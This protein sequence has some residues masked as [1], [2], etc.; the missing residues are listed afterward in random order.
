MK[1]F[2]LSEWA[3]N[4]RAFTA[5]L[6][7]LLMLGRIF[8]Y[9]QFD[10]MALLG[11]IALAGIIIRNSVILVD[12]IEQDERSGQNAWSAIIEA[13]V[14]GF[15]PIIL[16]AAAAILA[17]ISLS[18]NDFVGPQAIA[19]MGGL[20]IATVLIFFLPPTVCSLVQSQVPGNRCRLRPG[21]A[22]RGRTIR[23]PSLLD[24]RT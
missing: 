15:R 22:T 17:M 13:S 11:I 24:G 9:S 4:H 16:T 10:F 12:Q 18:T 21:Q 7:A 14:R 6:M 2:N 20:L 8:A 5:F 3:L 1:D 23:F 19:I